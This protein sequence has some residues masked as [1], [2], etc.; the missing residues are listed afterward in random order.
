MKAMIFA[1]GYG[2]RLQPLTN[3]IPKALVPL[4]GK[5]LL[6]HTLEFIE[7]YGFDEI[8]I[9]V[10]HFS[11]QVKEFVKEY[12]SDLRIVISDESDALLDTGGGL[13]RASWFF[14]DQKP[15]LII[16]TDLLTDINLQQ[17][18]EYHKHQK[19]M[20]TLAVR[21]DYRS[22]YLLIDENKILCGKGNDDTGEQHRIRS[23]NTQLQKYR[24]SGIH[25]LDP[26]VFKHFPQKDRFPIME[27]YME[28]AKKETV[29]GFDHSGDLWMDLGRPENLVAAE[30]LYDRF[31]Q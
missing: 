2:S 6:Q 25:I 15:F 17:M 30:N 3:T 16:N 19:A 8:I 18:M 11:S 20:V 26:A 21:E 7:R 24:F 29:K 1:A 12:N 10:H 22:R 31:F 4:R 13:R 23:V 5:P 28:V 9:N 27:W 14:D